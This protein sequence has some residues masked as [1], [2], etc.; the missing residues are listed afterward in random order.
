[1]GKYIVTFR[2]PLQAAS[3]SP[4]R[5]RGHPADV[6]AR[7]AVVQAALD[8]AA[9]RAAAFAGAR[10]ALDGGAPVGLPMTNVSHIYDTLLTGFA[11]ELSAEGVAYFLSLGATVAADAL[12]TATTAVAPP[13]GLDRV[14]QRTL[15]LNGAY[16]SLNN[17]SNARIYV[18]DSASRAARP[19]PVSGCS[20]R[21][22]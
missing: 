14:D 21:T 11:G 9:A 10:V 18:I 12:V 1:V 13:W 8:G 22:H 6:L 15:P 5:G 16:T 20:A 7:R 17:A 3:A 4:L 19:A 2:E